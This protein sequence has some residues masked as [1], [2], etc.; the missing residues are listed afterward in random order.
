MF[1]IN[2][3]CFSK[4]FLFFFYFF[5][6]LDLFRSVVLLCKYT[7]VCNIVQVFVIIFFIFFYLF[8]ITFGLVNQIKP[9]F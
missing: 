2:C 9:I 1:V 6:G 5:Y 8:S 3:K 4:Y 7:N